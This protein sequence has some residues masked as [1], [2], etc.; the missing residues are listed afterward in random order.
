MS[1]GFFTII[2]IRGESE[3]IYEFCRKHCSRGFLD[4]N[5]FIP[6]P[7]DIDDFDERYKKKMVYE[8]EHA[9][10]FLHTPPELIDAIMEDIPPKDGEPMVLKKRPVNEDEVRSLWRFDN[11]GVRNHPDQEYAYHLPKP[12]QDISEYFEN[13]IVLCLYQRHGSPL[14][15]I[16]DVMVE[17]HPDLT[18]TVFN[19]PEYDCPK[20]VCLEN[21]KHNSE[22]YGPDYDSQ[23]SKLLDF[24]DRKYDLIKAGDSVKVM[25]DDGIEEWQ[26]VVSY[27]IIEELG[28]FPFNVILSNITPKDFNQDSS[29]FVES[30]VINHLIRENG[31][32][33]FRAVE[34][35]I[36]D[37]LV[38]SL[39]IKFG[40][41]ERFKPDDSIEEVYV[42][43]LKCKDDEEFSIE[44]TSDKAPRDFRYLDELIHSGTEEIVLDSDIMLGKDEKSKYYTG[45]RLD[46]DGIV[47][48][49]AGHTIDACE[50]T[51]I[52]ECSGKNILI[53]NLTFKNGYSW[54]GAAICNDGELTIIDSNFTGNCADDGAV[55]N[56]GELK[57][58]NCNFLANGFAE[59]KGFSEKGH[60]ASILNDLYGSAISNVFGSLKV[61]KSSFFYNNGYAIENSARKSDL[62]MVDCKFKYN[63][64]VC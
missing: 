14:F 1:S 54:E 37:R 41:V 9:G 5:T 18:I 23:S 31:N 20:H 19:H 55:Y 10:T 36:T 33:V 61:E 52:F 26:S 42:I 11:W 45:I 28:D 56:S 38:E 62:D 40:T 24:L 29:F 25:E 49:G 17:M 4:F 27:K 59:S 63:D 53:K 34:G 3:D 58:C 43:C 7:E 47:I 60:Y 46:V 50:K 64:S 30:Y 15:N 22:K 8:N 51:R 32:L 39:E 12:D 16:W 2:Y 44:N 13:E 6:E 57:V 48:D 35:P 21:K